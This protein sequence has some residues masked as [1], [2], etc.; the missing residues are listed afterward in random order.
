MATAYSER[1]PGAGPA[2]HEPQQADADTVQEVQEENR[3]LR[4]LVVQ[5]SKLVVKYV[6]RQN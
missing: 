2:A 3:R 6:V 5:L 1:L 4:E